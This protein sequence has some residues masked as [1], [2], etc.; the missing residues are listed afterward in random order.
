MKK[1]ILGPHR[2]AYAVKDAALLDGNDHGACD[3]FN[4]N[5]SGPSITEIRR[6]LL[7]K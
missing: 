2:D 4:E 3:S 7:L 6:V 5:V 1:N